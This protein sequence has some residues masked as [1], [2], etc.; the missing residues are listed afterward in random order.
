MTIITTIKSNCNNETFTIGSYKGF[1]LFIPDKDGYVYATK[2]ITG[3]N[4]QELITKEVPN[5]L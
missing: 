3:I 4:D 2:L 5:I 1:L